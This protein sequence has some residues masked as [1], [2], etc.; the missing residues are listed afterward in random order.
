MPGTLAEAHCTTLS[1]ESHVKF[2]RALARAELE[3]ERSTAMTERGSS[4]LGTA[5]ALLIAVP[6]G[7]ALW[8]V[9]LLAVWLLIR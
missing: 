9:I 4:P 2:R 8:G 3:S 6:V 7:L 5:R 1:E